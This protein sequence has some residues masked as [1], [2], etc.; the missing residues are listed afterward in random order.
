MI[1]CKEHQII[2]AELKEI[3]KCNGCSLPSYSQRGAE[4]VIGCPLWLD[5]AV[6]VAIPLALAMISLYIVRRGIN[7]GKNEISN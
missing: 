7:A 1:K 3:K 2:Q 4:K 5:L 6:I